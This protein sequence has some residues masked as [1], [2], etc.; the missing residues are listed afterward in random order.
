[1]WGAL[2]YLVAVVLAV[3]GA[4]AGAARLVCYVD[5]PRRDVGFKEC[6]HLVYG[7]DARGDKLDVLLKDYRKANQRL[8]I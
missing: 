1:M 7:G 5:S 6:T 4:G 2:L 8:K 3:D